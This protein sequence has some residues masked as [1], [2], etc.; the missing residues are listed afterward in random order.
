M[1]WSEETILIIVGLQFSDDFVLNVVTLDIL[2]IKIGLDWS[3]LGYIGILESKF[4]LQGILVNTFLSLFICLGE[5]L[6]ISKH[7]KG[8]W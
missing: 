2:V 5:W 4:G 1:L 7:L 6:V 3:T 8:F